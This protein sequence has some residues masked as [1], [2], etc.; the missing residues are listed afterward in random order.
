MDWSTKLGQCVIAEGYAVGQKIGPLL[1]GAPWSIGVDLA[2]AS[3]TEAWW[4]R[5]GARV[6]VRGVVS[7]AHDR[8]T[9]T[10]A[11]VTWPRT[12][13][14]V[15]AELRAGVG[16][17]VEL[18]GFVVSLNGHYWFVYDGVEVHLEPPPAELAAYHFQPVR[19]RGRLD[20]RPMP[21]IDQIVL[22]PDRDLADAY[23]L[24]VD[25]IGPHPAT[26]VVACE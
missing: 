15:D 5:S 9:L 26:G 1:L 12:V 4:K 7:S 16:A 23:V 24:A 11:T 6:R 3:A 21:R 22:K 13:D 18:A 2:E 14:E 19:L 25:E 8:E 20:R 17:A 10:D